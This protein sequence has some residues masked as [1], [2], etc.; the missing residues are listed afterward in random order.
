MTS[1]TVAPAKVRKSKTAERVN[2]RRRALLAGGVGTAVASALPRYVWGQQPPKIPVAVVVGL[3]GRA[4]AWGVPVAD[5]IKLCVDQINSSGGIKS[6]GGAQIELTIA[7][8]QSNPQM[9]GTQVERVIQVNH[10]LA[11]M[12]NAT[13]GATVVGSAAAEKNKTALLSTDAA[14][15][16]TT[17]GLKY[18]FR[19]GPKAGAFAV[20]AV[21]FASATAKATG[22][23]PKK[24]ATIADDSTFSQDA[25]NGA[26]KSLKSTG[27]AFQENVSF[28]PGSVSD[29]APILQRPKL[30][31]V[32]TI[33]QATFAPD[34]IQ[35]L[36]AMKTLNYDLIAWV[37]VLGAPYTPEFNA[38]VKQDGSYITNAVG[39]VPE[40]TKKNPLLAKFND[41]YKAKF[42][43][44][45]DDQS[46]L[47][48]NSIAVLYD[49]LGRASALN[50]EAV[51]QAI[52][53]TDLQQGANPYLIRDGVKFDAAGDNTR[54]FGLVM[55]LRDL[56]QRIVYPARLATEKVVWPMPKWSAR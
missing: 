22:V 2:Q 11:V 28:A 39:F 31:G 24:V 30:A 54:A 52:R 43:K 20:T 27:W 9:A 33:F 16:L 47:G 15:T 19:L 21:E 32:D 3:T 55:Q 51:A 13:S 48:A 26:L 6:K 34:G 35:I 1:N 42:N 41:A 36:R 50:R 44:D 37:H 10:A 14:D 18:Y 38:A 49:A 7:D 29:F 5:A 56:Q 12:G 17:K 45:L 40:L 23:V 4:A 46:S 8:H 53:A 25:I